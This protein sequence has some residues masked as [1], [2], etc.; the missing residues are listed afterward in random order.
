V[1]S[2]SYDELPELEEDA[3]Y[4]W[5]VDEVWADGTVITGDV[6]SFTVGKLVGWWKFDGNAN[7]SSGNGNNGTENGDPMYV[8]GK[9][10][11]AISFDGEGDRIEVPATVSGNP[12]LYP[13]DAVSVSAWVRTTV[14]AKTHYSLI[15]HE[16][17][18]TSLQTYP[19]GAQSAAFTNQDGSRTLHITRFDWSKINDGQWHHYAVTYNKGIHE[20]WIDGTKEVSDNF[21][22]FPLWTGDNQP[23]VFG[24]RERGEGGGE[25]YPGEL[26]DVRI[27]NYALSKNE[28]TAL[29]NE[30]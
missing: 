2:P 19:L 26:D 17:H 7:D 4:Y 8:A 11:Q 23:W 22:S 27:Y 29:C 3:S 18:F 24:G 13:A 16:F 28:I 20:V 12:E 1:Q 25:H 15:R 9:I 5:R 10:G 21:G 14:P 6:W 30:G